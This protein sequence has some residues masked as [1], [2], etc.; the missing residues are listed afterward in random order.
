M[1]L[2]DLMK[3]IQQSHYIEYKI[4]HISVKPEAE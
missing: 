2:E 4:H 1:E 3:S